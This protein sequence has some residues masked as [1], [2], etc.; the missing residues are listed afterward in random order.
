MAKTLKDISNVLTDTLNKFVPLYNLDA[1]EFDPCM[2][3]CM[4]IQWTFDPKT[5][6]VT[7]KKTLVCYV[8]IFVLI[9]F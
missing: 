4:A 7:Q 2:S 9:S 5:P 6:T 1:W 8:L 3:L